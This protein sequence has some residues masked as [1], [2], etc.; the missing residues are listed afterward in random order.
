M[1]S[2]SAGRDALEGLYWRTEILQAMFWMRGEG[3]ATDADPLEL[4]RFLATE[5]AVIHG[6][7]ER[8]RDDGYVERTPGRLARYLLTDLGA[9]E[10]AR[11]FRDEFE[12]FTRAG[13]GEC[14]PGC[15]CQDPKH[16]LDA[17]NGRP[18]LARGA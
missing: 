18:E 10:G 9:S 4:A 5:P 8:L 3:L 11:S 2:A 14:G 12:G 15:W 17:C 13:H 7:L 16:S 1:T 6:Q